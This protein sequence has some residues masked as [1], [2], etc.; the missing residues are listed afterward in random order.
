[1]K[2]QQPTDLMLIVKMNQRRLLGIALQMVLFLCV[3]LHAL[4]KDNLKLVAQTIRLSNGKTFTLNIPD[5]F[6]ISVAMEGLKRARFLAKAPDGRLF[7]TDMY[8]R[9]DNKRGAVYSLG[10]LDPSTRKFG[11]LTPYLQNLHNPNSIAFYKDPQGQDWLYLALTEKLVRYKFRAGDN[12][13]SSEPEVL[14]AYPAYGL[15]YKYGGWHLTRTIA[16]G[17]GP[18]QDK[19]FIAV[20]SSC[21]ACK[22]DQDI[23][24][25]LSMMD[26]NGNNAHI[27][28]S[29]LRNAVG[30][31]IVNGK[32]YATNMGADHLGDDAPDDTMFM[33]DDGTGSSR[34]TKNYGWPN[35]YFQNGKV[36]ADPQFAPAAGKVDCAKVPEALTTFQAHSSPLGFAFFDGHAQDARLQEQ[37]LVAL[38]GSGHKRLKRGYRV[39]RVAKGEKPEDFITGFLKDGVIYGRPCDVFAMDNDSF[40]V[41]EDYSGV[42]YF[43]S[44][45]STVQ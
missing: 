15:N 44:R 27:L 11:K 34:A 25:T 38:H 37:F 31:R 23:R 13:P 7:V 45:K 18:N 43:V 1:M 21:N 30:L 33:L 20:G 16:F 22:E 12:A 24:A 42:I 6:E 4:N 9:S 5:G 35:C 39:V 10:N 26:A 3:P 41:T 40:L 29:G 36:F 2:T 8:N 32:L 14:A 28:A 17:A 19:L